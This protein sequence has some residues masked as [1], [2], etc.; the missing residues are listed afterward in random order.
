MGIFRCN[1]WGPGCTQLEGSSGADGGG[2]GRGG[3]GGAEAQYRGGE[4]APDT[5]P[6]DKFQPFFTLTSGENPF[7]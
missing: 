2:R 6:S 1:G 5:S 4:A 7:N 3:S